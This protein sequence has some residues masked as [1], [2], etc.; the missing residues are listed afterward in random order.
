MDAHDT[1]LCAHF[2]Q[3]DA[4]MTHRLTVVLARNSA[5]SSSL[6][7]RWLDAR[8]WPAIWVTLD[9][10][11]N[12]PAHFVQHLVAASRQLLTPDHN[13]EP[14]PCLRAPDHN[15]ASGRS[16]A[17][18]RG[19][20]APH[21]DAA[22]SVA[23]DDIF[24]A[25]LNDMAELERDFCLVLDGYERVEAPAVHAAVRRLLDYPPPHMHVYIVTQAKPPLQLPRLRV[26]RQLLELRLT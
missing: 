4:G 2:R 18:V 15:P 6:V 16:G 7:R 24:A 12:G 9:A 25:W 19:K 13:P 26:R 10:A 23:V 1:Q 14:G 11:D 3:L 17:T 21:Q 5:S 22:H 20:N 8:D